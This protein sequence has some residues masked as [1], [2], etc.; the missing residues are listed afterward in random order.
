M[1]NHCLWA[2]SHH[3]ICCLVVILFRKLGGGKSGHLDSG[4][5]NGLAGPPCPAPPSHQAISVSE[6][7]IGSH[8]LVEPQITN[9]GTYATTYSPCKSVRTSLLRA[10]PL[11]PYPMGW[12]FSYLFHPNGWCGANQ[13]RRWCVDGARASHFTSENLKSEIHQLYCYQHFCRSFF[14]GTCHCCMGILRCP[15]RKW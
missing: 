10:E 8:S 12:A 7:G 2:K 3:F 5:S 11:S 4:C 15:L 6:G 13:Y 9:Q 1:S 14:I